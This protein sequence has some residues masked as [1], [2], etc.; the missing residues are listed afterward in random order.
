[1]VNSYCTVFALETC[2]F[3]VFAISTMLNINYDLISTFVS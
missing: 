2:N 1:M 3:S